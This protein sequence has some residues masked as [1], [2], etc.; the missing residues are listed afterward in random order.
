MDLR[1]IRMSDPYPKK[2]GSEPLRQMC[3]EAWSPL[4]DPDLGDEVRAAIR[5]EAFTAAMS[6][7]SEGDLEVLRRYRATCMVGGYVI[8]LGTDR[9]YDRSEI[10]GDFGC[11]IEIPSV[12]ASVRRIRIVSDDAAGDVA[13]AGAAFPRVGGWIGDIIRRRMDD[14]S[15]FVAENDVITAVNRGTGTMSWRRILEMMPQT[16]AHLLT[17]IE[18]NKEGAA[19]A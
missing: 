17:T 9:K 11:E 13:D 18:A 6:A 15:G 3:R 7:A 16:R 8:G 5:T 10:T 2:K 12:F 4:F 14:W 1:Q 19:P